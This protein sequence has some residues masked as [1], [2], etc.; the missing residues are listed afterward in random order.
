[1]FLVH[2]QSLQSC[3]TLGIPMDCSLPG[4][5]MNPMGILQAKIL[6][7]VAI[8]SSRESSKPRNRTHITYVSCIGRLVLYH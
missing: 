7:W 5:S 1:M 8:S 2:A 4:S 3:P 6:E